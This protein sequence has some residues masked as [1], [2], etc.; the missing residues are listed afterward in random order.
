MRHHEAASDQEDESHSVRLTLIGHKK[1]VVD[2]FKKRYDAIGSDPAQKVLGAGG[3]GCSLWLSIPERC[4]T[5]DLSA[6]M[7]IFTIVGIPYAPFI[8]GIL[9]RAGGIHEHCGFD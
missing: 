3:S 2:L 4:F 1:I 7:N 8:F 6:P 9:R 5:P